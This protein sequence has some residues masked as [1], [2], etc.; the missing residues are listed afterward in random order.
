MKTL[1]IKIKVPN[2]IPTLQNL[3]QYKRKVM[4]WLFSPRC[5]DCKKRLNTNYYFYWK[6]NRTGTHPIGIKDIQAD[7]G[8]RINR[9]SCNSCM[10]TFIHQCSKDIGNCV[11]CET[12]NVP[13]LGYTVNRET[14]TI[15]T[16]LWVWWNGSTF[17]M[18]CIDEMLE[19]GQPASD[20]YDIVIKNNKRTLV[21][22]FY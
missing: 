22:R 21:P 14:N 13:V 11:I 15:I 7:F 1:N 6:Q 16:F 20:I 2:W 19:K 18:K 12:Q 10:K 8:M 17:C 3:R 4:W 5:V 9:P